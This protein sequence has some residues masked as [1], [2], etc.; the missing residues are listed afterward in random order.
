MPPAAVDT[1][2]RFFSLSGSSPEDFDLILTG[3]LGTEGGSI[4]CELMAAS[5][6][7]IKGRYDDCGMMIYDRGAQDMHAGG[8]GCGCSAVVLA[9]YIIPRLARGELSDILLLGTGAMMSP[10][11]IQQGQSIP[12]VAHLVRLKK[13]IEEL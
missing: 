12:A 6:Y 9:S 5:G 11:S 1:L 4:L 10:A 3:D 7:D 2:T 13:P 8:S